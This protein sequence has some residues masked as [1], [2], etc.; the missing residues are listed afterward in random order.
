MLIKLKNKNTLLFDNFKFKCCIGKNGLKKYKKEGDRSTPKGIFSLE[1]LYFRKDR[2]KKLKTDLK[3]KKIKKN[4]GWCDDPN[5][6]FYNREIKIKKNLNINYENLYRKDHKY[7]I[8]IVI[9]YNYR[10]A[11]KGNGSAI[12]I[13]LTKNYLPTNGCI[14]LKKKDLIILSKIIKKK[15]KIKIS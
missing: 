4:I 6:K 9:G 8:V 1:K 11:I 13:H 3:L 15:T 7:D 5:S 14:A 12:F 10:K 2:I